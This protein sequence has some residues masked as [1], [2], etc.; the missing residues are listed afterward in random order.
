MALTSIPTRCGRETERRL[1]LLARDGVCA[2][3]LAAT[4]GSDPVAGVRMKIKRVTVLERTHNADYVILHTDLPSAVFPWDRH[5]SLTFE[6]ASGSGANYVREHF[7]I[8]PEVIG[9]DK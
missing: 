1:G 4:V 8:E 3:P 9:S 5:L 7:A 2:D 6:C